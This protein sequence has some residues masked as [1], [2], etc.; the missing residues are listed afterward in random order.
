[1][2]PREWSR[3][4][5]SV[6]A[7]AALWR[8]TPPQWCAQIRLSLALACPPRTPSNSGTW[9]GHD[10]ACACCQH[11]R[12]EERQGAKSRPCA[13]EKLFCARNSEHVQMQTTEFWWHVSFYLHCLNNAW[14]RCEWGAKRQ[15]ILKVRMWASYSSVSLC[16]LILTC[17]YKT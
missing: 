1:M 12:K 3:C 10:W 5:N 7:W 15:F 14:L 8:Q 2:F 17:K 11:Q 9:N 4:D 6:L 16:S 13:G